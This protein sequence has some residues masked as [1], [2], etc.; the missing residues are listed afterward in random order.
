MDNNTVDEI[1]GMEDLEGTEILDAIE[2]STFAP[3]NVTYMREKKRK[4]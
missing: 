3:I 4:I 1:P 2:N